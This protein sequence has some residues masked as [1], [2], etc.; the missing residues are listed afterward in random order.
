MDLKGANTLNE[1]LFFHQESGTLIVTDTAFNFTHNNAKPIRILARLFG[2]YGRVA[3]L[4]MATQLRTTLNKNCVN[5]ML[6][7]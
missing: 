3:N 4:P 5:A 6:G 7:C 2:A 1:M